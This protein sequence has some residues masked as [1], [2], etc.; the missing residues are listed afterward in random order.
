[1]EVFKDYAYYYNTFYRDKNYKAEAEQVDFLLKKYGKDISTIVNYG[2]G[3]GKHDIEFTKLGYHCKGIDISSL[4]IDIAK[5][6]A[7]QENLDIDF[8]TADIRNFESR[9]H[10]DAV[11]SLFHVMSYQNRN[12]DILDAFRSAR[13][14]LDQRGLFLFDVWYGPGVLSD[15]PALRVKEIEDEKNKLVRIAR[16]VMHDKDN[17]VAVHYEIFVIDKATGTAKLIQEVHS[18]RYFF[19]PELEYWLNE[20]GFELIDNLD[21]RTLGE[22]DYSSWTS[23]FIARAIG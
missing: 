12:R 14:A 3:T 17:V 19:R 23:Y 15:R 16:P 5:E 9:R 10:F 13:R 7:V 4:M 1:M 22:T 8:S 2:C 21:C 20:A 18:M 6:N 11:I